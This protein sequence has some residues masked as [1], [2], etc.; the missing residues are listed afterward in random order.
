MEEVYYTET[1]VKFYQTT[2]RNIAKE[3]EY[4][5]YRNVQQI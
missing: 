4:C 1:N 2:R 5:Y 3:F